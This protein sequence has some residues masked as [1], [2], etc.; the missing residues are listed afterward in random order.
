MKKSFL[1]TGV[2]STENFVDA[3]TGEVLESNVKKF[4][5][6][7]NTKEEFMLL[8][9]SVLP[10]FLSLSSPAKSV[11]AYLLS[12]YDSITVFEIGGAMRALI[13]SKTKI[14]ASTV[15]NSLTELVREDLLYSQSKGLYQINPRYAFK[16]SSEDRKRAL[17]T[18]IELKYK[19]GDLSE[20]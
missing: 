6:L 2:V 13:A 17:K 11:Y 5:Y 19:N 20:Q 18:I 14:G 7:A 15:A 9:V 3:E 12:N 4:T 1:K 10:I 8:Y 16:G